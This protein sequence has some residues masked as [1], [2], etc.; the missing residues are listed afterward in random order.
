MDD[1]HSHLSPLGGCV[2]SWETGRRAGGAGRNQGLGA[3]E[4]R[5]KLGVSL[6]PSSAC[7]VVPTAGRGRA[8]HT[9][10]RTRVCVAAA[11]GSGLTLF[12]HCSRRNLSPRPRARHPEPSGPGFSSRTRNSS[13]D[14]LIPGAHEEKLQNT[15]LAGP[16]CLQTGTAVS[17]NLGSGGRP[18]VSSGASTCQRRGPQPRPASTWVQ[19]LGELSVLHR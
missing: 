16:V 10:P 2:D 8:G 4:K 9:L 11:G 3:G 7:T 5:Q 14:A 6:A 12:S 15:A 13:R 17:G 19:G 1:A 18:L